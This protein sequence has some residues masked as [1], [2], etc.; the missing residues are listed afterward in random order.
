MLSLNLQSSHH[1]S[2][3]SATDILKEVWDCWQELFK[4]F[5]GVIIFEIF[6][7]KRIL[8]S[9]FERNTKSIYKEVYYKIYICFTSGDIL[10]QINCPHL[11]LIFN[12]INYVL[13]SSK[14]GWVTQ[15]YSSMPTNNQIPLKPFQPVLKMTYI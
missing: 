4:F 8:L 10:T 9:A 13:V 6:K 3:T 7:I 11:E 14:L 2:T 5:K 12:T 1:P 15:N